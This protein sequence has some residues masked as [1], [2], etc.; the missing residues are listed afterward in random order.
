MIDLDGQ[1]PVSR[2]SLREVYLH[3]EVPGRVL[4]VF[5]M[6][7]DKPL[8]RTFGG[9]TE[10]LFPSLRKRAVLKEVHEY[11]RVMLDAPSATEPL[12]ITHLYGFELT[13]RGPAVVAQAVLETP[14]TLGTS[15][16]ATMRANAL[17]EEDLVL[18]NRC[19]E[20]LYALKVRVGD[21]NFNNLV[22]GY[23][24]DPVS[25]E[26]HARECVLVDGFGDIAGIP[27]RSLSAAT[28]RLGLDDSFKRGSRHSLLEWDNAGKRLFWPD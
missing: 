15:L 26:P 10:H 14:T 27:V 11:A 5:R 22:L 6:A 1:T 25:N 2:G 24:T 3:P 19:I 4:K 8:R 23:R 17:T 13:S 20:R 18:V 16:S 21:A 28:N 12:P 9:W 7:G